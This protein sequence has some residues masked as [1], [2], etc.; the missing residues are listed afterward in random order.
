MCF[1]VRDALNVGSIALLQPFVC[2]SMPEREVLKILEDELRNFSI[3]VEAPKTP[4]G[5]T[6]KTYS[7]KESLC[8]KPLW[9]FM[10]FSYLCFKCVQVGGRNDDLCIAL[11]LAVQGCRTF[12]A[13]EKYQG[14]RGEL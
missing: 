13:S 4:F 10:L 11:Q 5:K 8:F 9:A 2:Q 7:G 12:Y 6:K 14:F 1:N 3:L